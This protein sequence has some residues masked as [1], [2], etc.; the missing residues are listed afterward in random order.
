MPPTQVTDEIASFLAHNPD[1]RVIELLVPDTNGIF[2]GKRIERHLLE[3]V[4]TDGVC[5]PGSLFGMD[6]TGTT[7]ETTGLGFDEGDAD[8]L[9]WPVAGSLS[10]VPWQSRPTAQMLLAMYENDGAPFFADPRHVLAGVLAQFQR[11]GLTPVVALEMEFYLIDLERAPDGTPQP[12]RSPVTAERERSTQVYGMRELDEYRRVLE[13]IEETAA[14]QNIPADTAVSEY[15]PGQYEINLQHQDDAL[16][17]CDHAILLKHLIK[18][19]VRAQG[20]DVTFMAKPYTDLAGSGMHIH[21]SVVDQAGHNIFQGTNANGSDRLRHAV[22]GL[23]ETMAESMALFSPNANSFRRFQSGAFVPNSPDWG[24]NNRT[25]ALRIPAGSDSARRVEHRVPGAD[26]NPYLL[27]AAVLAGMH[28]GLAHA[29]EPV[30]AT[31]GNAYEQRAGGLPLTWLRAL[32]RFRDGAV[33]P[34][35]LNADFRRVYIANKNYER[36]VFN[37]RVTALEYEWYLRTV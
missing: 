3:K 5:L 14:R 9:C 25:T 21:V 36:E 7:V 24:Y 32:E 15:A 19:V 16:R 35:Y 18:N 2:R 30:P 12:P 6:I 4:A 17:A 13:A 34:Q 33:L 27:T 37:K 28:H 11:D 20:M 1:T 8:R 23:L 22:G 31:A 10:V 29:V 26:A